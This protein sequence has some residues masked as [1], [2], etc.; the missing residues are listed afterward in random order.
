MFSL[1]CLVLS[2]CICLSSGYSIYHSCRRLS[3]HLHNSH[4]NPFKSGKPNHNNRLHYFSYTVI[5]YSIRGPFCIYLTV[6]LVVFFFRLF[7]VA[8]ALSLSHSLCLCPLLLTFVVFPTCHGLCLPNKEWKEEEEIAAA[9][10]ACIFRLTVEYFRFLFRS[11]QYCC[12][13]TVV[14]KSGIGRRGRERGAQN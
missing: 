4:F 12:Q 6:C 13:K 8:C 2:G 7:L 3:G 11:N 5:P 10:V 9:N 14:R 1:I